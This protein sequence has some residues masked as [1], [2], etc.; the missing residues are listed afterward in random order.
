[1]DARN[2][3]LALNAQMQTLMFQ[4]N[5]ALAARNAENF[6]VVDKQMNDMIAQVRSQTGAY[7]AASLR[8]GDINPA[9]DVV[10]QLYPGAT[11]ARTADDSIYISYPTGD[12]KKQVWRGSSEE[13]ASQI[14]AALNPAVKAQT[15]KMQ[16]YNLE[17]AKE[18]V[19]N[20]LAIQRKSAEQ[21]GELRA[22]AFLVQLKAGLEKA[23]LEARSTGDSSGTIVITDSAN[24]QVGMLSPV[25]K[26]IGNKTIKTFEIQW[27]ST[28]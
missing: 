22:E 23:K 17:M 14:N 25:E 1:M 6:A 9:A 18:F 27:F 2:N 24:N 28:R 21:T 5:Q 19:K 13:L 11:V 16:D 10:K 15:A 8:L 4:R 3:V 12:G 26:T 7:A 20:N